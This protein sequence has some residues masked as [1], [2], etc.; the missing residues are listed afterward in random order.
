MERLKEGGDPIECSLLRSLAARDA[1]APEE[2]PPELQA[3]ITSMEG[4]KARRRRLPAAAAALLECKAWA[5][6]RLA[7]T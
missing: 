1:M 7:L 2:V 6:A 5:G 4:F 3:L